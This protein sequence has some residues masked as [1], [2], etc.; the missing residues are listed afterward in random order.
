VTLLAN[1]LLSTGR[2]AI[3][4]YFLAAGPTAANLPQWHVV[5]K[6]S[7]GQTGRQTDEHLTVS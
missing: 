1:V 7:M 6:R 5:A 2:A 4:Q 3:D